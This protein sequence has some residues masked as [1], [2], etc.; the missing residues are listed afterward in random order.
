LPARSDIRRRTHRFAIH[1]HGARAAARRRS[2]TWCRSGEF[3]AQYHISGIDGSPSGPLLPIHTQVDHD[4]LPCWFHALF[5][6]AK[7]WARDRPPTAAAWTS[8]CLDESR[9]P[10]PRMIRLYP[11]FMGTRNRTLRLKRFQDGGGGVP[12]TFPRRGPGKGGRRPCRAPA[13][14]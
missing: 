14:I 7:H 12:V 5:A 6:R 1:V 2:R 9:S 3:I 10:G 11:A 8:G 4:V 13:P